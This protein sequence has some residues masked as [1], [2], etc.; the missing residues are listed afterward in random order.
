MKHMA[1]RV[2]AL[3]VMLV[4]VL[5]ATIGAT[6]ASNITYT[7]IKSD[8]PVAMTV[9]GSEVKADE[10]AAYML[11]NMKYYENMYAQYGMLGLWDDEESAAMLGPAMP[12]AA[13]DQAI[14]MRVVLQKFKEAGLSLTE[15][16]QRDIRKVRDDMRKQA[17]SDE[18]Y[19]KKIAQFGFTEDLYNNFMYISQCYAALNEYYFGENGTEVPADEELMQYF[20][21]NYLAAKHILILGTDPA[22]GEQ[23]RTDEEAKAAAQKALD[24]LNAGED[25]DTVMKELSEDS[26]LEGNPDG[27]IFTEGEMVQPFY[28]GA[29]ALA[30]GEVSGLVKSDFGYH[31]IKRVPIDYEGQLENYKTTLLTKMEKTMDALLTKWMTEAD[32]QTT[33]TF[34]EITYQNVKDYAPA[35][36]AE[37][38]DAADNAGGD[39]AE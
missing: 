38:D 8:A 23:K 26:G 19:R 10:Y 3:A 39:T 2:V 34:D 1:K 9:N 5:G 6:M 11:Y 27:Y 29:K 36:L 13:K 33:E 35:D 4:V 22:T 7:D 14:Y 37:T 31:I 12:D 21:D 20:K 32:V 16:Q 30:E 28:E 24:R 15:S 17:G 25:F 18:N